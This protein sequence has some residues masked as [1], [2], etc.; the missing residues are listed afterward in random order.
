MNILVS[1]DDGIYSP[2]LKALAQAASEFG[3][4][5]VMASDVEQ[6][7]MGH[8]VTYSR[9]LSYRNSPVD[10]EGINA[11]RVNGTPADCVALGTHLNANTDFVLSGINM[12]TNLGNS[13]WHSGTLAAAK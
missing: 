5:N 7:S 8:A 1:N 6:S 13:L 11:F 9:P 3:E 10:F 12:G 4:V 2:G